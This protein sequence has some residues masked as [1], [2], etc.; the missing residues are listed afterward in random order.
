MPVFAPALTFITY[1]VQAKLRGL[2]PLT[3]QLTFTYL[4]LLSM[5]RAPIKLGVDEADF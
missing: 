3:P 1:A 5:V 4:A 2:E